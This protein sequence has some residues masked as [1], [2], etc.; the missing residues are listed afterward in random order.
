MIRRLSDYF[1]DA[2]NIEFVDVK[3][4]SNEIQPHDL[5]VCI[6]GVSVDRHDYLPQ[7]ALANAAGAIIS[8]EVTTS[9]PT[10]RVEDAQV[11]LVSLVK[12]AYPLNDL[13][14]IG[15]TGTDGKT[16]ISTILGAF[17]NHITSAAV[18]GTN[19]AFSPNYSEATK[20]TTPAIEHLYRLLHTFHLKGD[21]V[22]IMEAGSEGLYYGRTQGLEFDIAI[23]SNLT[24]EHLNT[25]KTM[26]N[27]FQAKATLFR[28]TKPTGTA[29]INI[30]DP[31]AQQ[32][33]D[34]SKCKILTYG[35]HESCDFR[36]SDIVVHGDHTAFKFHHNG[37]SFDLT[38]NLLGE[39]NAYNLAAT[40]AAIYAYGVDYRCVFSKL[41]NLHVSG[42]LQRVDEGQPF[43][44]LVDYA[45]TPNGYISLFKYIKALKMR[46]L[47]VVAASAGGRDH[48]KRPSMGKILSDEADVVVLTSEDPR[49]EDPIDIVKMMMR[50]VKR[51]N[52][53]VIIDRAK[54][55]E[56]AI[57]M[58]NHNDCVLILGKG[59]ENYQ[60]IKD[61]RIPF[62][63]L[64][65]AK[66][67]ILTH[68]LMK[69]K[70]HEKK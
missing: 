58:A 33:I 15:V 68:P 32:F 26:E 13:K 44:V 34:V 7:A 2:P 12:Q 43:K 40:F 41:Q 57:H 51:N 29:I 59:E 16:T 10:F 42:R 11:A 4:N 35:Q 45:H 66:H 36:I 54:A 17:L 67:A 23:F 69:I 27:Y 39:F 9:L 38:T 31:Y 50:D 61:Q 48:D 6:Q 30:D 3:T 60:M 52:I 1:P 28:Q 63:D 46:Q 14:L 70:H 19:G 20:N 25:H 47:I 24:P 64:E 55:I 53:E 65:Q 5:F 62:N 21:S 49:F 8:K 56:R 18:I 37:K 22:A